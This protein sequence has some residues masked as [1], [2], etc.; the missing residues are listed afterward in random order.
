MTDAYN[1]ALSEQLEKNVWDRLKSEAANMSPVE[2]AS[3]TADIAGI[4]DPT[5][6][7]DGA[8]LVLSAVQLDALGVLL[9][10]GS[11]VPYAGDAIAKPLKIAKRA[12]K[13]AKALEAVLRAGDNLAKAGAAALKRSGLSLAQVA[14][15]RKRALAKVQQA[16]LD[17][18]KKL[19]GSEN[20]VVVGAKGEKRLLQM[21]RKG[22]NGKWKTPDGDAPDTGTGFFEFT[23][24]KK[25]PD[26]REVTE[27]KFRNGTPVF[28]DYIHGPKYDLWEVSGDAKIDGDRLKAMMRETNPSW[29]PPSSK[30][31][32][33]HHLENGQVGYVPRVIHDRAIGGVGHTGGNSMINNQLF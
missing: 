27:I 31:Y 7:S 24:P 32:V 4:F 22:K 14:A 29:E 5:P 21:P 13:T 15:A 6:I 12:P 11:M 33:L 26:G 10:A 8:G 18:R 3:V 17:A 30:D 1:D 19:P 16:M 28:D 25:L 9:S 20:C 2:Y 23:E